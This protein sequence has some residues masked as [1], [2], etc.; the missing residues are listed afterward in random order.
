MALQREKVDSVVKV[1]SEPDASNPDAVHVVFKLPSGCRLERRFLKSHSLEVSD[2][3][4]TLYLL[5]LLFYSNLIE[6]KYVLIISV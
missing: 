1:P 2:K 5:I 6:V 4:E 3:G